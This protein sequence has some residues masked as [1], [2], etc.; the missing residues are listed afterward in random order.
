[1]VMKA[2][3]TQWQKFPAGTNL[4]KINDGNTR[5]RC[6]TCLKLTIKTPERRQWCRSGVIIVNFEHISHLVCSIAKF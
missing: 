3:E 4:L 1:M 2:Y 5:T 6:K